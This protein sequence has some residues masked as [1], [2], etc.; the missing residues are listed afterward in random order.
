METI[1][2]WENDKNQV[3]RVSVADVIDLDTAKDF[4]SIDLTIF[5]TIEEDRI[6]LRVLP[7]NCVDVAVGIAKSR[8]IMERLHWFEIDKEQVKNKGFDWIL[9]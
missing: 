2:Y 3:C 6:I 8:K 4:I 5:S 1:S 9:K 7:E